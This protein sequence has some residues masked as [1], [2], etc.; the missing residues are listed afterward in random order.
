MSLLD[1]PKDTK[2]E[3]A[4]VVSINWVTGRVGV[5]LRNGLEST[6]SCLGDITNL[7]V[8]ISVLV[9]KVSNSYVILSLVPSNSPQAVFRTRGRPRIIPTIPPDGSF[10]LDLW[11]V[12]NTTIRTMEDAFHG[13]WCILFP[14]YSGSIVSPIFTTE[15][16]DYQVSF[17]Y[18]IISIPSDV[19][20]RF[21]FVRGSGPSNGCG[22]WGEWWYDSF[23]PDIVYSGEWE[24][25]N[26]VYSAGI[27][28]AGPCSR[29]VINTVFDDVNSAVKIDNIGMVKI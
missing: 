15:V 5:F 23:Y 4:K 29:I 18:K 21:S 13:S 12:A 8:G 19:Q 1:V 14:V 28:Q 6:A 17:N 2:V 24:S 20:I 16:G 25:G 7:Y 26:F 3:Q 10:E 11:T 9:T 22:E 27:D